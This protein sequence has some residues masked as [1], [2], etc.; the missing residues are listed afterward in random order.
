MCLLNTETLR[1]GSRNEQGCICSPATAFTEP[2]AGYLTNRG[3]RLKPTSQTLHWRASTQSSFRRC[4]LCVAYENYVCLCRHTQRETASDGGSTPVRSQPR[5]LR[6]SFRPCASVC[7]RAM[8]THGRGTGPS[9]SPSPELTGWGVILNITVSGSPAGGDR[10][11][12]EQTAAD[13]RKQARSPHPEER[14]PLRPVSPA[15]LVTESVHRV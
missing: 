12:T 14:A 6:E 3:R 15:V 1:S 13:A 8:A 9:I 11:G 7:A 4:K 2:P 5:K 10:V